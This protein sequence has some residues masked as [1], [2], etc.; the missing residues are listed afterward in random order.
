MYFRTFSNPNHHSGVVVTRQVPFVSTTLILGQ[1]E[2]LFRV[3]CNMEIISAEF[4]TSFDELIFV[5]AIGIFVIFN[6][7]AMQKRL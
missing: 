6:E 2:S 3:V 1:S 4:M 7:S 5:D